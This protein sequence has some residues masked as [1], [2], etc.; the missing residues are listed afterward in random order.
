MSTELGEAL[1]AA[2]GL[3]AELNGTAGPVTRPGTQGRLQKVRY[4]HEAMIELIIAEPTLSQGQLAEHF[5]YSQGWISCVLASDA[6][7]ARLATRRE[8]IIDPELRATIKERFQALVIQSLA[9]LQKKLNQ[10]TV[11]DTLAIKAAELGAKSLGLGAHA[12]PPAPNHAEDRLER[13]A[14]RLIDLQAGM[15]PRGVTYEAAQVVP[16]E[17]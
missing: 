3:I 13:L 16:T 4:T 2:D 9:V 5:G 17:G 6:F 10:P 15:Q 14:H 8:E 1:T 12:P 7:Q 11:S